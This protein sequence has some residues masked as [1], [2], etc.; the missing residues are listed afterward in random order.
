[1][2]DILKY[3]NS[4]KKSFNW[5]HI[6]SFLVAFEEGS[7]SAAAR[8]L[9]LTQPTLSRQITSLEKDLGFIVF[10]RGHR[11][12]TLTQSGLELIE[13]VK[14]MGNAANLISLTSSGQSQ[15]VEG[16]VSITASDGMSTYHLPGLLKGLKEAA[17][18]IEIEI[19]TSNEIRDL[20]RREADIAIRHVEPE[21]PD[22]I[23]KYI[24]NVRAHLYASSGYLEK[25]GKFKTKH[26]L[27]NACFIG[28]E[29]PERSLALYQSMGLPIN[30]KN[31]GYVTNDGVSR[32]EIVK[33][34]LGIGIMDERTAGMT[35]GVEQ[36][37]PELAPLEFP[38]WLT[39]HRE[40][41]SSRRIRIVFDYLVEALGSKNY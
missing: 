34:G 17:P 36:V 26:D 11:S 31:I 14:S 35:K 15:K 27:K 25:L 7:L 20:Q 28:F 5:N 6:Q 19:V 10:E 39:T 4:N 1:M 33:Q 22:L 8:A 32:W 16:L 18:D 30:R 38:I 24:C 3:M 37:L 23:T 9:G 41:H 21:Q 2:V 40:L 29:T 12:L 13:H